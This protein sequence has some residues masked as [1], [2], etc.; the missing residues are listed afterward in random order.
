LYTIE[1][2][3]KARKELRGIPRI[4]YLNITEHIDALAS[5][6]R[7]FG[8]KKLEESLHRIR[9]G[10]YRIVFDIDDHAKTLTILTIQHRKDVYKSR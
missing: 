6:P 2:S 8:V 5:V 9:V 4:Y 1:F 10:D 3:K 7:P